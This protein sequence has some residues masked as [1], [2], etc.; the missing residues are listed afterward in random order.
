M[1]SLYLWL[2]SVLKTTD[3]HL[4]IFVNI[5]RQPRRMGVKYNSIKDNRTELTFVY[6]IGTH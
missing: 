2:L 3:K 4:T 5:S 1:D 6:F